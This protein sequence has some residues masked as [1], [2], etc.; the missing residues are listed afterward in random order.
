MTEQFSPERGAAFRWRWA[1]PL[2]PIAASMFCLSALVFYH[3]A[4][5]GTGASWGFF[6]GAVVAGYRWLGFVPS[7]MLC[8][9]VF[10]WCSIW[11]VTGRWENARTRLA[12]MGVFTLCIAI[13]VN[14]GTPTDPLPP[15]AGLAGTYVAVR[16]TSVIGY[17]LAALL[18]V[19]AS[20][21]SLL[22]ATDFLFYRYF[23][24]L[25]RG[26][27]VDEVGVEPEATDAFRELAFTGL[28]A[29]EPRAAEAAPAAAPSA[30]AMGDD[31][32]VAEDLA[33]AFDDDLVVRPRRRRSWSPEVALEDAGAGGSAGRGDAESASAPEHEADAVAEADVLASRDADDEQAE[34]DVAP[35]ESADE[36]HD[37]AADTEADDSEA[38]AAREAEADHELRY[39]ARRARARLRRGDDEA[40]AADVEATGVEATDA[41][42]TA[43]LPSVEDPR[44]EA[45]D[46]AGAAP[47]VEAAAPDDDPDR[48]DAGE[49]VVEIPRVPPRRQG[50]LFAPNAPESGDLD[51]AAREVLAA[52]RAS[53]T[54]LRRHLRCTPDEAQALLDALRAA[55]VVDGDA[56]SPSGRVLTTLADWEAR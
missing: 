44:D 1:L 36:D 33:R 16:L 27:V 19:A 40:D 34:A 53:V 5:G 48:A 7:F 56:G 26:R 29:G 18:T 50:E 13:L 42:A 20:L 23:E 39:G 25:A 11:F 17:A 6:Q 54:L 52:G 28:Y 45:L 21:A 22:L 31:A 15:H 35:F 30:A 51:R 41:E 37:E 38:T 4:L 14:L 12:W 9:L 3:T 2:L 47:F 46:D 10:V 8:L 24:A 55:G 32:R 49:N 43:E